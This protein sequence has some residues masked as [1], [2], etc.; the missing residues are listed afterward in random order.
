[1]V[2]DKYVLN[3]G[4]DAEFGLEEKKI[5]DDG[6]TIE[7]EKAKRISEFQKK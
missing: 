4:D 1:M 7:T 2:W 6:W 3:D 5:G